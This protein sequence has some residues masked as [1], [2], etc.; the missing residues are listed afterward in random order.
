MN[1]Q[2]T[3]QKTKHDELSTLQTRRWTRCTLHTK[4]THE[5]TVHCTKDDELSVHFTEDKN[6]MNSQYI[7]QKMMNWVYTSQKTKH[8]ELTVHF[9]KDKTWW[10]HSTLHKRQ[11][12]M[13]SQQKTKLYFVNFLTEPISQISDEINLKKPTHL[14]ERVAHVYVLWTKPVNSWVLSFYPLSW[15]CLSIEFDCVH[16]LECVCERVMGG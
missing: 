2:Y 14:W 16:E 1:S 13:N 9:T 3:S 15:E 11:N 10:T 8:D 7:A 6:M 5:L 12:M 4:K